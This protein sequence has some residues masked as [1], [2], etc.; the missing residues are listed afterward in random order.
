MLFCGRT[1]RV[2][3]KI[4][5]NIFEGIPDT[6]EQEIFQRLVNTEH[7][8]IERII[9]RGQKSPESGW[10]DQEENEWV[11]VLK[12]EAKLSFHDKTSVH[13]RTGDF[14]DIPSHKKHRVDWTTRDTETIWLA[15]HYR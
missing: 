5:K 12:G 15:V 8:K 14:I 1:I 3:E 2:G 13:L 9:S 10:Y 6:Q 4:V 7:T 11:I